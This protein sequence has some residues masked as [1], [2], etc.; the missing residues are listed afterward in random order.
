M[1]FKNIT[2]LKKKS[3]KESSTAATWFIS[4]PAGALF[5]LSFVIYF[6]LLYSQNSECILRENKH[7]TELKSQ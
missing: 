6:S 4:S 3:Q 1:T 5:V 7:V 2:K